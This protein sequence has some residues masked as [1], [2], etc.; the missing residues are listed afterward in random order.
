MVVDLV[1]STFWFLVGEVIERAWVKFSQSASFCIRK[2]GSNT[3]VAVAAKAAIGA[4]LKRIVV[5]CLGLG[6]RIYITAMETGKD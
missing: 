4:I 1:R 5:C 2:V 3:P 6:K